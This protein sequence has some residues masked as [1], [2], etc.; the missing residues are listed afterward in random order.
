MSAR[1]Q[2]F[3]RL[4]GFLTLAVLVAGG[5]VALVA[6]VAILLALIAIISIAFLT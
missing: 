2:W 4:R 1:A 6:T 5:G 3:I